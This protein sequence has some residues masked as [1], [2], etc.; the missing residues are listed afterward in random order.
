MPPMLPSTTNSTTP[1][2]FE[3]GYSTFQ[4][5]VIPCP[6]VAKSMSPPY[7][8]SRVYNPKVAKVL[9]H[10]QVLNPPHVPSTPKIHVHDPPVD[11]GGV[12]V[13]NNRFVYVAIRIIGE[14]NM[15]IFINLED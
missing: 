7:R 1:F 6:L 12:M 5:P 3:R 15:N 4:C 11:A 9:I 2:L 13:D 8:I 14:Y 10:L